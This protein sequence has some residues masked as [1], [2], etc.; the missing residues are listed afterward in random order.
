MHHINNLLASLL[1]GYQVVNK[2]RN[3]N[4]F[5]HS[6]KNN[7]KRK[8]LKFANIPELSVQLTPLECHGYSDE[9]RKLMS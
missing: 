4:Q 1:L 8:I 3:C 2:K 6:Y 7:L 5:K 9:K